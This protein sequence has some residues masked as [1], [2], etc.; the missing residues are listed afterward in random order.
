MQIRI[1]VTFRLRH[2]FT[3]KTHYLKI[4]QHNFGVENVALS[5]PEKSENYKFND[6]ILTAQI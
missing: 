3:I 2:P 6:R 1:Y 5:M 4:Y